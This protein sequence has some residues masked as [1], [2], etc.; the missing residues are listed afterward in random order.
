MK[1]IIFVQKLKAL[2]FLKLKEWSIEVKEVQRL[3]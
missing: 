1:Y 2:F 3:R